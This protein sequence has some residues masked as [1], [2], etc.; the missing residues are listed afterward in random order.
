MLGI[1]LTR[2]AIEESI[3]VWYAPGKAGATLLKSLAEQ[4]DGVGV[5]GATPA[6][7]RGERRGGNVGTLWKRGHGLI[8]CDVCPGHQQRM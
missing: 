6:P 8:V 3:R 5:V 2:N 7:A 1:E 4:D